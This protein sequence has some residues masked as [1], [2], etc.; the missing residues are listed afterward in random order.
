[1]LKQKADEERKSAYG[2][3]VQNN[4]TLFELRQSSQTIP[5]FKSLNSTSPLIYDDI[6]INTTGVKQSYREQPQNLQSDG[7]KS[8]NESMLAQMTESYNQIF[9]GDRKLMNQTREK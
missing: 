9:E 8:K 7:K 5:N 1:M 2:T 4:Q 6:R 3:E